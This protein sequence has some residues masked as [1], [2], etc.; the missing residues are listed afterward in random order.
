MTCLSITL[1]SLLSFVVSIYRLAELFSV[2]GLKYYSYSGQ[3]TM[4]TDKGYSF[5]ESSLY[6]KK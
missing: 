2:S 5:A 6:K 4:C 1:I 3:M